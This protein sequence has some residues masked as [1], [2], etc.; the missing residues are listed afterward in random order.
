MKLSRSILIFAA[1]AALT[2]A[3][4]AQAPR[5]KKLLAIG[6]VAGFEHDSISNGLA[7]MWRIGHDTGL[8]DTY[9]RTDLQIDYEKEDRAAARKL[10]RRISITST[11]FIYTPRAN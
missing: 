3:Q 7:T 5:K 8:W 4:Q 9:I 6:A 10:A 1:C 11:R 2:F